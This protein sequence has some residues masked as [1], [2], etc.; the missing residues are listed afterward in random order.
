M[1]SV[2]KKAAD[3]NLLFI[4]ATNNFLEERMLI[5]N[6]EI[7]NNSAFMEG[8]IKGVGPKCSDWPILITHD[9]YLHGPREHGLE[10]HSFCL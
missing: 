6:F 2:Y 4:V 5:K 3:G 7:W 8:Q 10:I 9:P 1:T